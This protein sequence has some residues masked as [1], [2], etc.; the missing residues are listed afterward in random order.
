MD[1]K[2]QIRPATPFI[3]GFE[4]LGRVDHPTDGFN[5]GDWVLASPNG[6]AFAEYC[7]V[8]ESRAFN[9]GRDLAENKRDEAAA[10]L[11][12]Y[13]TAHMALEHRAGGVKKGDV[14]VVTAGV[15]GVGVAATQIAKLKGA[16]VISLVGGKEKVEIAKKIGADH[17]VDYADEL[18][19]KG[20]YDSKLVRDKILSLTDNKGADIV[21]D[22]VGTQ[23]LFEGLARSMAFEGRMCVVGFASGTIPTLPINL[24]LVKNF[25]VMGVFWGAYFERSPR[26]SK[27][28]TSAMGEIVRWWLEGK[29][30]PHVHQVFDL[31]KIQDALAAVASRKSS[32]KVVCR[33]VYPD[34]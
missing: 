22:M 30:K 27:I 7:V 6:G 3:P 20:E 21:V 8:D 2:Y 23:P 15:G 16:T 12:N 17:V 32:G 26:H 34:V 9:L 18:T 1:G 5:K 33:M 19:S 11:V 25:S 28:L 24:P 13:G 4:V 31:D 14:V 10:L 29:I